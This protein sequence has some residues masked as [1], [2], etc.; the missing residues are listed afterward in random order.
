MSAE[1]P[2]A[3]WQSRSGKHWVLLFED[4]FGYYCYHTVGGS[5]VFALVSKFISHEEAI[6]TFER[7]RVAR[8]DFQPDSLKT[9]MKRID[10]QRT[11]TTQE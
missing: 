10:L 3:Q 9:P 4:T 11:P 1:K 2:I 6:S 5:G 8:G 7:Q